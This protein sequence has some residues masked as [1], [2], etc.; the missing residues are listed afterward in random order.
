[1]IHAEDN[2]GLVARPVEIM[3]NTGSKVFLPLVV[4]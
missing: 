1:V 4:R 2:D 3:V